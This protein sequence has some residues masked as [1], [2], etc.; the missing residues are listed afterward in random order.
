M[1]P[2]ALHYNGMSACLGDRKNSPGGS[3]LPAAFYSWRRVIHSATSTGFASP[4]RSTVTFQ[5]V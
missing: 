1:L 5:V 4:S 3:C 2:D